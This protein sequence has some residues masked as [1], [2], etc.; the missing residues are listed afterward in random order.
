MNQYQ[1]ESPGYSRVPNPL[2]AKYVQMGGALL[3]FVIWFWIG[4]GLAVLSTG[5]ILLAWFNQNSTFGTIIGLVYPNTFLL[6]FTTITSI[7]YMIIKCVAY[8]RI[9]SRKG[10]FITLLVACEVLNICSSVISTIVTIVLGYGFNSSTFMQNITPTV[11]NCLIIMYFVLSVRVRTYLGS[12]EYITGDFFAKLL[13]LRPP[14]P[15]EPYLVSYQP[16]PYQQ[17]QTAPCQQQVLYPSNQLQ[18]PPTP[19][20]PSTRL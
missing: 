7:I 16:N 12:D 14:I 2:Y 1:P 6:V 18:T 3:F 4:V 20:D 10:M 11:I 9:N 13:K 15:V 5:S 8:S 17:S 19:P